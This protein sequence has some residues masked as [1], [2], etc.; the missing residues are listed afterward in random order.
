MITHHLRITKDDTGYLLS[1]TS[2]GKC[3][4]YLRVKSKEVL[5]VMSALATYHYKYSRPL[6]DIPVYFFQGK[7]YYI[8][9]WWGRDIVIPEVDYLVEGAVITNIAADDSVVEMTSL[10]AAPVSTY[11]PTAPKIKTH[12]SKQLYRYMYNWYGA[13][14]YQ[15]L[16]RL[17]KATIDDF[18]VRMEFNIYIPVYA[19]VHTLHAWR[20]R[21]IHKLLTDIY[22]PDF[23]MCLFFEYQGHKY[24]VLFPVTQQLTRDK[25]NPK[26]LYASTQS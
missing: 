9:P 25:F 23:V 24:T 5:A 14:M 15:K 7:S 3:V 12:A 8:Y 16:R 6:T 11:V 22:H 19:V 10:T 17:A 26:A 21:Q 1:V 13:K 4:I 2:D 18:V 20:Y